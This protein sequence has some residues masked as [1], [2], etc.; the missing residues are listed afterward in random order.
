MPESPR[1]LA[2]KDR[3]EE[4]HEVLARVHAKGDRSH[5]FVAVELQDI[6]NICEVESQAKNITYLDLFR[7][8]MINRTLIGLMVQIWSQLTGMNV[9]SMSSPSVS[10]W[11][12]CFPPMEPSDNVNPSVL[13]YL[14][15][16]HGRLLRRFQP[17]SIFN[18]VYYQ[19]R[20]D[21][22]RSALYG[23]L[24]PQKLDASRLPSHGGV[25]VRQWGDYGDTWSMVT[26]QRTEKAGAIHAI[27]RICRKGTHCLHI[28]FRRFVRSDR[29]PC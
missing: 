9:M 7:P 13:Y 17:P 12:P 1:W 2:S 10:R 11:L 18:P 14:R 5:P 15:F 27:G 16:R 3:W 28:S 4:A 22:A 26:P 6:R 25:Y 24:R 29:G 20:H 21:L 23:L 8:R 19:R